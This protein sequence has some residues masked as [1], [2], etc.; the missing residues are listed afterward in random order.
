MTGEDARIIASGLLHD[1]LNTDR[2]TQRGRSELRAAIDKLLELTE[3]S[4]E[5]VL[6]SN[7]SFDEV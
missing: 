4:N 6:D 5:P 2:L 7:R 1:G 3:K